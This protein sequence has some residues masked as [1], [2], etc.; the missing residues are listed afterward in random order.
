MDTSTKNKL[1]A[2]SLAA[3]ALAIGAH[4]ADAQTV[5]TVSVNKTITTTSTLGSDSLIID[6]DGNN[7][8]DFKIVGSFAGNQFSYASFYATTVQKG[9]NF[10]NS[11]YVPASG[12][13]NGNYPT[14]IDEATLIDGNSATWDYLALVMRGDKN[15][16]PNNGGFGSMWPNK[17]DKYVGLRI[18]GANDVK[19]A[20]VRMNVNK[21]QGSITIVDYA[22]VS[23]IGLFAGTDVTGIDE[24]D[25]KTNDAQIYVNDKKE[26]ILNLP[27]AIATAD[28]LN[29][30]GEVLISQNLTEQSSIIKVDNLISGVYV[31]KVNVNNG[32]I[33]RK[34]FVR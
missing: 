30:Q 14:P 11:K 7:V 27:S 21:S 24:N 32:V 29:L 22:Y 23:N 5:T 10:V 33:T 4:Q 15:P 28:I 19:Y 25:L 6:I 20:W 31:V 34:V 2:Y 18:V 17:T 13:F 26:I 8:T 1:K 3:G 9:V 12:D 16:D